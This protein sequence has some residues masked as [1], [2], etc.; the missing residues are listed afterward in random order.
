M[1]VQPAPLGNRPNRPA[2]TA[3]GR[4]AFHHPDTLPRPAPEVGEAQEVEHPRLRALSGGRA[5]RPIHWL[6]CQQP[7]LVRMECQPVLAKALGEYLQ[8]PPG[9]RFTGKAHDEVVRIAD[10][11]RT[12]L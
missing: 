9:V 6:E 5:V 4:T 7:G 12:T 11:E 3:G 1:A 8:H 10:E 2:E